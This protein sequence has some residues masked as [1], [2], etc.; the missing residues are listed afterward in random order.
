MEELSRQLSRMK[1]VKNLHMHRGLGVLG[2]SL[3]S[4]SFDFH[5]PAVEARIDSTAKRFRWDI[6]HIPVVHAV[7]SHYVEVKLISGKAGQTP[8]L[9]SFRPGEGFSHFEVSA[10][11]LLGAQAREKL[12]LFFKRL[13]LHSV[14]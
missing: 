9:I 3:A 11:P 2:H 4:I 6:E 8:F 7:S 1:P 14:D 12:L 5:H 13:N 10:N